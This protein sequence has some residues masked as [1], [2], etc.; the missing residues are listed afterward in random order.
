MSGIEWHGHSAYAR[1]SDC[2]KLVRVNKPIVGGL[3]ICV[4]DCEKR[5]KHSGPFY[6]HRRVGPF[7]NRRDEYRCWDCNMLIPYP[8]ELA[9]TVKA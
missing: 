7:W 2:R 1:C 4:T 9:R 5:G 8:T 3:H 6:S